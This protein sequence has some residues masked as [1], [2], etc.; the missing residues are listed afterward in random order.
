[1]CSEQILYVTEKNDIRQSGS[2]FTFCPGKHTTPHILHHF[3]TVACLLYLHLKK[4]ATSDAV[5]KMLLLSAVGHL[6]S[7]EYEGVILYDVTHV[8]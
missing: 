5:M 2:T 6:L 8:D 1:M 4:E 3:P 7:L